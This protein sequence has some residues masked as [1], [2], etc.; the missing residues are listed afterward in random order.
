MLGRDV[1]VAAVLLLYRKHVYDPADGL[2]LLHSEFWI[3]V[4]L[5]ENFLTVMNF[6]TDN[7]TPVTITWRIGLLAG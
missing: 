5:T 4:G 7:L 1:C 2:R 6:I 3:A